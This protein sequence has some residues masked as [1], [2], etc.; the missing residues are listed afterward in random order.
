MDF[1]F[2]SEHEVSISYISGTNSVIAV[3]WNNWISQFLNS[4]FAKYTGRF[5]EILHF[6]KST[7]Q[8]YIAGNKITIAV[9]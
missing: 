1:D 7:L 8:T 6:R 4:N 2:D 9:K 3:T 5:P